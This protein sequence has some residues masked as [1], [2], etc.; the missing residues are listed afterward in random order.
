[1]K[2]VKSFFLRSDVLF[3]GT[4][5]IAGFLLCLAGVYVYNHPT[6]RVVCLIGLLLIIIISAIQAIRE[7]AKKDVMLFHKSHPVR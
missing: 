4:L 2:K 6:A 7:G 3:Y 5:I 1:M